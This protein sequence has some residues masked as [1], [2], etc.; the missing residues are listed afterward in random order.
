MRAHSSA[1]DTDAMDEPG[2][3]EN[4]EI[5]VRGPL[6]EAIIGAFP[7]LHAEAQGA[8]TILTGPLV[9]QAALNGVLGQIEALGLE[10]LEL[11]RSGA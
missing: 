7:G 4:Y 9:D 2:A 6:G 1:L 3:R 8:D 10:L 5:R 11:R